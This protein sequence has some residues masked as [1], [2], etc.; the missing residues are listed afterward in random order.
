MTNAHTLR[1]YMLEA[2]LEKND[3]ARTLIEG[4]QDKAFDGQ[5]GAL[6]SEVLR[7]DTASILR[8]LGFRINKFGNDTLITWA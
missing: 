6:T 7:E 2:R 8:M 3:Q 4:M 1:S 5:A